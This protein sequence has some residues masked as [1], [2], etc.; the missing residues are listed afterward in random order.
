MSRH[1]QSS[2]LSLRHLVSLAI[3]YWLLAILASLRRARRTR[4]GTCIAVA[5]I[6]FVSH[7]RVLVGTHDFAGISDMYLEVRLAVERDADLVNNG[8][9]PVV[10]LYTCDRFLRILKKVLQT[11]VNRSGQ[12]IDRDGIR[13][14]SG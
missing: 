14:Q 13:E 7:V 5:I 11:I 9:P 8:R 4:A 1:E 10:G 12:R 3:G 2:R 6:V